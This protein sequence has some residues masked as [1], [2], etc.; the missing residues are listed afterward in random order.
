MLPK[1]QRLLLRHVSWLDVLT[2]DANVIRKWAL[3]LGVLAGQTSSSSLRYPIGTGSLPSPGSQ[4]PHIPSRS[5]IIKHFTCTPMIFDPQNNLIHR[6][7]IGFD[8]APVGLVLQSSN[9]RR[10]LQLQEICYEKYNPD[11]FSIPLITHGRDLHKVNVLGS[12][13]D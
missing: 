10:F 3:R 2:V 1:A 7:L 9:F 4:P 5:L 12:R 8:M 11:T 13:I 6:I